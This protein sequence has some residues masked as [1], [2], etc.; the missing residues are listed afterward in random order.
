MSNELKAVSEELERSNKLHG[1]FPDMGIGFQIIL[2]EFGELA[3]ANLQ[4]VFEKKG[5][6][7]Y[8]LVSN[9]HEEAIQLSAMALK[10]YRFIL[11]NLPLPQPPK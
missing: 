1:D 7:E 6:S 4:R 11:K 10:M 9:V 2:E 5:R 8:E 3:Q